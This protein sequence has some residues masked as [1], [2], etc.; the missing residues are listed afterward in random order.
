VNITEVTGPTDLE[1]P[2]NGADVTIVKLPLVEVERGMVLGCFGW[3]NVPG[4]PQTMRMCGVAAVDAVT[5]QPVF[6]RGVYRGQRVEIRCGEQLTAGPAGDF[7]WR[8]AGA[9][10]TRK[11]A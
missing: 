3:N 11:A 4:T 8:F 9:A 2:W 7:A 5:M 6:D 10:A 1:S